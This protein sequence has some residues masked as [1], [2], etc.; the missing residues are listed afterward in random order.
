MVQLNNLSYEQD[1][2]VE[3][4]YA[5]R[6]PPPAEPT[7]YAAPKIERSKIIQANRQNRIYVE[8]DDNSDSSSSREREC[9][10]QVVVMVGP[11]NVAIELIAEDI[12]ALIAELRRVREDVA[13]IN[14]AREAYYQARRAYEAA[15]DTWEKTRSAT[16]KKRF[17]RGD[18][19][20]A[21]IDD[22]EKLKLIQW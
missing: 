16:L 1:R 19:T 21:M 6:C 18:I 11:Q 7:K 17:A 3:A 2:L 22:P 5:R 15:K 4:E 10:G 20:G 9:K 13:T 12:D 14:T 8:V